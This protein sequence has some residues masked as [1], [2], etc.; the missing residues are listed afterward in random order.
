MLSVRTRQKIAKVKRLRHIVGLW[1][2]GLIWTQRPLLVHI[3][4]MR[5]CNLACAYCNEYDNFSKPVPLD[6]MLQRF[7]RLASFG[8]SIV[9]I[10]GG[11]P[12]MHPELDEM[13]AHIR[14]RGMFAGVLTNGYLL[15]EQRIKQLNRVGLEH[16]QISVDNVNPDDVSKKSLKVLDQKL[17]LLSRFAE[18]GIN[19][20]TVI[21]SGVK[22]P[23]DAPV[24][25]RRATELGFTT[26]V[27]IVHESN[28][29][30]NP[31]GE[32]ERQIY[33]ETRKIGNKNFR[34]LNN[35]ER[36]LVESKPNKWRCR[37]G[38]RYLYID[39]DGLVHYCSQQRGYPG[40]PLDSYTE[41][42]I[43]REYLTEKSCAPFCTVA[44]VN[45]ISVFDS[46]RSPQTHGSAVPGSGEL[47]EGWAD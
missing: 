25:A 30:L 13:I 15:T 2:K 10:S 17:V 29:R 21:G 18:F 33:W 8:T 23:E 45:R 1:T 3:I 39:E 7:D 11:E 46:W 34:S 5:R 35:F 12:L 31:L 32:R 14:Q 16:L 47:E 41:E 42:D 4:P 24:I 37:A 36:N 40:V 27:G 20:N 22:H 19:I 26:S 9:G 44:C 6:L 38:G 28:G 43:R